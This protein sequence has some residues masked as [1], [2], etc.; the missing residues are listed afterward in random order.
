MKE[1]TPTELEVFGCDWKEWA[2]GIANSEFM[3]VAIAGG[4]PQIAE[5]LAML[6][7]MV[8]TEAQ[9]FIAEGNQIQSVQLL[10]CLKRLIANPEEFIGLVTMGGEPPNDDSVIH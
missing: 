4:R 5:A 7:I 6:T 8:I 1:R 3:K 2:D 10:N 9:R